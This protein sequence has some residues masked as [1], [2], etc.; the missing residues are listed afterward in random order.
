MN[1]QPDGSAPSRSLP[2]RKRS[3]LAVITTQDEVAYAKEKHGTSENQTPWQC[4]LLDMLNS[5]I[6]HR[7]IISMLLFDVAIIFT[8]L[9][10]DAFFPGCKYIVRDAVS[11][12]SDE[13]LYSD[14]GDVQRFLA[15]GVRYLAE[16][17]G[18][19]YHAD[20]CPGPLV[21][22]SN[23]AGCEDHK[24]P[25]VEVAHKVLF[26]LTM[27]IL[28]LFEIE[29]LLK[30]YLLGFKTFFSHLF[31][32]LDL[33]IVT[34]SLILEIVFKAVH[35]D[36]L[37]DIVG[38]LIL[39]RLWRFVRIGHGLVASTYELQEEKI[40]ELRHYVDEVEE[41]VKSFGAQLPDG[42]PSILEIDSHHTAEAKFGASGK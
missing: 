18:D 31:Y 21:E 12:C 19:G 17:G 15:E 28:I 9:A 39:F 2:G 5:T 41:I 1:Q 38:I 36:I 30:V 8:E 4:R 23:M 27:I 29:L 14:G 6:G 42:R 24:Y 10:I 25:G 3:S 26:S 22:T 32:A 20:L 11:C 16:K 34:V 7:I 35:E 33:L 13:S 40:H 37:N